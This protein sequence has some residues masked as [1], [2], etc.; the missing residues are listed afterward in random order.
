MTTWSRS[1]H[2]HLQWQYWEGWSGEEP[3]MV[4]V[5]AQENG[6]QENFKTGSTG[7]IPGH[8][9]SLVPSQTPNPHSLILFLKISPEY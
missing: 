6:L 7:R 5:N 3:T 1:K 8:L 9:S 4:A 2:N